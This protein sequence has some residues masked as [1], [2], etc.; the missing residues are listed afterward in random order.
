[1]TDHIG[2][3]GQHDL[4]HH[5]LHHLRKIYWNLRPPALVEQALQRGEGQMAHL[6][7]VVVNTMPCTGRSPNDKYVV[8]NNLPEDAP[9]WWGKI[10]KALAPE[11][12]ERLY[13]EMLAYFQGRDTFV[14]DMLA[15]AHPDYALPIRI[16]TEQAWQSLFADNLFIRQS[17]E[18][19]QKQVPQFTLLAAPNF[20]AVPQVD[21]VGSNVFIIMDFSRRLIL[22]GGT[23][24]AGEVKK[25]IFT[26]MNYLMPRQ[27]VLSMHCSA[28]VG[29]RSARGDVALFFGLSGTGKTTLSSDPERRLIGDDEHGWGDDGVFNFE[30]GC[31]AK[32][33]RLRQ[34]LEPLIW[35][36]TRRFG[37]VIENV[38]MDPV[39]RLIDF[40]SDAITENTRAAYPIDFVPRHVEEGRAG[41]PENIFFLTADAFGVLPPLARLTPAQAMYYFLSGYT[42][43]LAGTEKGL[44]AEP[45]A[46]FSTCFGAPF[47]P[48]HP[49]NYARLLG[50]KIARHTARVWLVNT[51][52]TGGPYGTGHRIHLPYTRAMVRAA[53]T[54]RL[55]DLPTRVDSFFGLSTPT[56]CPEVPAEVLDPRRTWPDPTAYDQQA[57]ALVE[58]FIKNFCQFEKDVSTEVLAA[59]PQPK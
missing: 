12:F 7:A 38:V 49:N 41:H 28:N 4:S 31:Y 43:K 30:G 6:G 1:M 19:R 36:A 35:E 29:T 3:P 9:I 8:Q 50:E 26:L 14:Q 52:W 45:Q 33:I 5:G 17:A 54:G 32:T 10:N 40:D 59:G 21:G 34:E 13:Q 23:A 16:I 24:Y 46:T 20:N 39:T 37:T 27:G 48:L 58:N 11:Y 56:E 42:S 18:A 2:T 44:G 15:G 53:L 57:R 51:G 47:L 25:A 55:D 22:I